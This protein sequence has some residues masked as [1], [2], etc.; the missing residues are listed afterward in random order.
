MQRIL[1]AGG[2]L[3]DLAG[4]LLG[5]VTHRNELAWNEVDY[6]L[7]I[8]QLEIEMN[9]FVREDIQDMYDKDERRLDTN[10]LVS[11]LML[12]FGFGFA[13]EGTFP[14]D[15]PRQRF[16]RYFYAITAALSLVL[17]FLSTLALLECRNRLNTFM[18]MFNKHFYDNVHT[19]S[20]RHQRIIETAGE[21][22]RAARIKTTGLP[23]LSARGWCCQRRLPAVTRRHS[24]P[25][26]NCQMDRNEDVTHVVEIKRDYFHFYEIWVKPLRSGSVLVMTSGMYCNVLCAGTLIG[27]HFQAIYPDSPMD[28][29]LYSFIVGAGVGAATTHALLN[30]CCGVHYAVRKQD[31]PGLPP[32][33][34]QDMLQRF[35]Y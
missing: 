16:A 31:R 22:R 2:A 11:T 20:E 23:Q 28:W 35:L 9:S 3:A 19:M 12:G 21:I 5:L 4:F 10:L 13:V 29:I 8:R 32:W 26:L 7:Q 15:E 18:R 17:P 1:E 33:A 6:F 27:M 14:E 30:C 24:G 34:T 25:L